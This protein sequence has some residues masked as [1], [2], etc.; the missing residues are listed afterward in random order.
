MFM[1]LDCCSGAHDTMQLLQTGLHVK[2]TSVIP[3][4]IAL[5]EHVFFA[6][7]ASHFVGRW[8]EKIYD[9]GQK[10]FDD[11]DRD[12]I[13]VAVLS[14]VAES[15]QNLNYTGDSE[16][17]FDL[18]GMNVSQ[19]IDL[20][21]EVAK[22]RNDAMH[23]IVKSSKRY[24]GFAALPMLSPIEA[25]EELTR[26][27]QKY[28]FVGALINGADTSISH[29]TG[30]VNYY[31]ANDFNVL[32]QRLEELDVPLYIHPRET[33]ISNQFYDNNDD[34]FR[35]QAWGY[36]E[37]TAQLVI[38]L[39]MTGVFERYK[40]LKVILG[41]MGELLPFW[42]ARMDATYPPAMV[43][44]RLRRNFYIT[45]SGFPDT[46][47]LQHL[48]GLMGIERVLFAADYPFQEAGQMGDWLDQA[49]RSL[50]LNQTEQEMLEFKNAEKLLNISRPF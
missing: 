38:N 8:D 9:F 39:M 22:R 18:T 49:I 35:N 12:G 11:M 36:A 47:A 10:R 15:V 3:G 4:R 37:G 41:H 14:S 30:K 19:I 44:Q 43:K 26:C 46:L 16:K 2:P 21:I 13:Q 7:E 31:D 17:G 33:P 6:E 23:E 1:I 5:E 34:A 48:L 24:R 20:Q 45:T 42:A 25:A 28:G 50:A 29:I 40:G 32:W 27:V